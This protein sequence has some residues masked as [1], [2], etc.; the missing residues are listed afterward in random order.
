MNSNS[1]VGA[2]SLS[3]IL[4]GITEASL[5]KENCQS[6]ESSKW[7]QSRSR[8]SRGS[9]SHFCRK[10]LRR[11]VTARSCRCGWTNE[12]QPVSLH[13][14]QGIAALSH[15]SGSTRASE[16]NYCRSRRQEFGSRTTSARI[17]SQ[18][19]C[20]LCGQSRTSKYLL[21]RI[22]PLNRPRSR[23]RKTATES[24]PGTCARFSRGCTQS[25]LNA[26]RFRYSNCFLL[27]ADSRE[28]NS[29][30]FTS[31]TWRES[32]TD[33][34]RDIRSRLLSNPYS[35]FAKGQIDLVNSAQV[36]FAKASNSNQLTGVTA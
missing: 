25:R 32:S 22:S 18:S 14:V 16:F 9:N 36:G 31:S 1:S 23:N 21:P 12:G 34:R 35:R 19:G 27:S 24:I 11:V 30:F 8:Y 2:G 20:F 33:S 29:Y 15:V 4:S 7:C 3:A 17:R 5:G 13:F 6:R 26:F 10:G 28:W